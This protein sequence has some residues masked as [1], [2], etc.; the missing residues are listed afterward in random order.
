MGRLDKTGHPYISDRAKD[1]IIA[2]GVNIYPAEIEN[3]LQTHP[4]VADAAV[5]GIPDDEMGERVLAFCE[6]KPG[7]HATPAELIAHC[8]ET[9][10]V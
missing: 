8:G 7:R 5:I 3:A 6:L 9:L 2:G 4:A 1:M 10:A